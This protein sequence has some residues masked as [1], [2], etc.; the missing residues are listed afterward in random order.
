MSARATRRLAV[1]LAPV[2]ALLML[3]GAPSGAPAASH[4]S[5]A[6]VQV[7]VVGEGGA[8]M[9]PARTVLAPAAHVTVAGRSCA[10]APSTPLAVLAALHHAGGPPFTL[11]DYGHCGAS[12][13]SSSE[14]FVTSVGG[15]R[16]GG[17]NGWEYKVN[18]LAGST[19]AA[20]P[21]GPAG[22]GRR[23]RAG[24]E[25][26]WF[27]CQMGPRGC[28]RTLKAVPHS[29]SVA[30]GAHPAGHRHRLRR[31]R[32]DSTGGGRDG[33]ARVQLGDV[34]G[35]RGRHAHGPVHAG[36]LRALGHGSR[37][38]CRRSP[39][40]CRCSERESG[41]VRSEARGRRSG[42]ASSRCCWRSRSAAAALEPAPPPARSP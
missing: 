42:P 29:T 2:L 18:G 11:R 9:V 41:F 20:D 40:R 21:S 17:Q 37:G 1:A 25:V 15:Q 32:Q 23:L 3:A 31:R 34:A 35:R 26:L 33:D 16:N 27:Y 13:A 36:Q 38:W 19:G 10:V 4:P 12:P 28:Q 24:S 39:W 7:M 30:A 22:N 14:L 6:R 8:V 5:A